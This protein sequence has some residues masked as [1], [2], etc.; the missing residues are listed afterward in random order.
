MSLK[1]IKQLLLTLAILDIGL[2]VDSNLFFSLEDAEFGSIGGLNVSLTTICLI[3][4]YC[5]WLIESAV[6]PF[7]S[8]PLK[9][10]A[11]P[12][13]LYLATVFISAFAAEKQLLSWFDLNLLL[14]AYLLLMYLG[15]HITCREDI[16]MLLGVLAM[17][18]ILQASFVMLAHVRG[19]SFSLGPVNVSYQVDSRMDEVYGETETGV[20]RAG[21]SVGSAVLAGSFM[22]LLLIP[23]SSALLLPVSRR[24]KQLAGAAVLLGVPAIMLT[25]T[26][27]AVITLTVGGLIF[28]SLLLRRGW[29]PKWVLAAAIIPVALASV[30]F[31]SLVT[32]RT[33][34]DD[35]D[36]AGARV[37]LSQ[38]AIEMIGDHPLFGVGAGNCH[39]AMQ[40]YAHTARYRSEW[41]Y[42]IHCKYLLVWVE[43]GLIGLLSFLFFLGSALLFGWKSW[44]HS[45]RTI[46]VVSLAFVA[47]I[48]GHMVHMAVDVFN[49]RPQVQLLWCCVGILFGAY[50]LGKDL[51][52]E[53]PGKPDPSRAER[54]LHVT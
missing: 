11:F 39:L 30:P 13:I 26:R 29:L 47:G 5:I 4:L 50:Q 53:P 41:F 40:S 35:G 49:S 32:H 2:L 38:I 27:G 14:Q 33:L 52:S 45:D 24:I 15:N 16:G 19:E 18:L 10:I 46:A 25:G 7:T 12:A 54:R 8:R 9:V 51:T 43:S 6:T 20:P 31:I 3:G 22:A 36:S 37:H 21:G 17:S 42:S 44:K 48:I 34:Q 23:V 28:G 1:T